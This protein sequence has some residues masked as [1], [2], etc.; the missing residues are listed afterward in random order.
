MKLRTIAGLSVLCAAIAGPASAQ[1]V[2]PGG[3]GGG[4]T[5]GTSPSYG[6]TA[7]AS[8]CLVLKAA[9]GNF[10]S[11]GG[12]A[13]AAGWAMVF[14]TTTA[15][16][17]GTVTPVFEAQVTGPGAWSISSPIGAPAFSTGITVCY[18]STGPYTLTQY[19]TNNFMSGIYQ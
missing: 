17:N 13:N 5:P 11:A 9:S 6:S 7:T 4:I 10:Y 14:N 18:S 8:A 19:S 3:G 2:N 12:S 15:P 1:V 16:S